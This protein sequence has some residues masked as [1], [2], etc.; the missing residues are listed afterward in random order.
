MI[1]SD[2]RYTGSK[3]DLIVC[4]CSDPSHQIVFT[5]YDE[6]HLDRMSVYMYVH[7]NPFP[8][9]KRLKIGI[10]YIFGKR[11]KYGAFA[12]VLLTPTEMDQLGKMVKDFKK[13]LVDEIN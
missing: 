5:Q 1:T 9:W 10:Q 13:R 11:S 7:L 4:A 3:H 12:D 6:G 8:F 2:N